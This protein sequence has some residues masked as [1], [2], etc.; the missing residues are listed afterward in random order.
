MPEDIMLQ[1]AIDALRS[2]QRARCRDLLTRLLRVNQNNPQ[3]WLW[4]SA[5]VDTPKEQIYCLQSALRLDPNNL[6]IQQGLILLG[7]LPANPVIQP[8]L[9]QR[10]WQVVEQEVPNQS[11]W[12]NPWLRML[13]F[14]AS[15]LFFLALLVWAAVSFNNSRQKPVAFI[16]T[17][18]S[19]P[20]PTFTYTPTAM[21]GTRL[22]GTPTPT[23]SGPL[24]LAQK[25][26][27][28]YTPTPFYMGTP[29]AANEAYRIAFRAFNQGA[30]TEAL[31]HFAQASKMDPY[32]PDIVYLMAEIYYLQE[33]Y[34][35][36]LDAYKQ[37]AEIDPGFAPAYLGIART[38]LIQ[39]PQ[40]EVLEDLQ[41]AIELDP[42]FGLAYLELAAYYLQ[43]SELELA[44]EMLDQSKD[45]LNPS[46]LWHTY[47][48]Q[49]E[50][51][52]E[53]YSTAYQHAQQSLKLD[54]GLLPTYRVMGQ[55]ALFNQKYKEALE[56]LDIYT[57]YEPDDAQAWLWRA[58]ALYQTHKYS[59]AVEA[60]NNALSLQR[61]LPEA[62]FY[63]GLANL[64][65]NQGQKAVNDF[66][67]SLR[68]NAQSFRHN[69]NLGRA[70]LTAERYTDARGQLTACEDLAGSDEELAQVYYY[71]ALSSEALENRPAAIKD[72]QLLLA[73]PEDSVQ[74]AW[75]RKAS[76]ALTPTPT[77]TPT[78]TPSPTPTSTHS[79][80]PTKTAT[81]VKT[82]KATAA[83]PTHQ[84]PTL[85]PT[86][87][88]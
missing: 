63:R 72:W 17:S 28:Q 42:D 4:L 88:P 31:N 23:Q 71:R 58:Q 79:P 86:A 51:T 55:A 41:K 26:K 8:H 82:S 50:I 75:L 19:G 12:S 30:Y 78:F 87:K 6:T 83:S 59:Q 68:G 9:Q 70:L 32:A 61:E 18:T 14:T 85:T 65:L 35:K 43:H 29:H 27:L 10:Q 57:E 33:D 34:S 49:V 7:A 62:Y 77:I 3:Y 39:E 64:E 74:T 16:P 21:Q 53:D 24:S 2:G 40:T 25:L 37:S 54:R 45:I 69:L 5:A 80:T 46:A 76:L 60:V 48:A 66:L 52:S 15:A 36:A 47:Q 1:Q 56:A 20:T 22:P 67:V 11:A 81:G 73:L 84:T 38:S 13:V 44:Q